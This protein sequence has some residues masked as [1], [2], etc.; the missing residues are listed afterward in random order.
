MKLTSSALVRATLAS[1]GSAQLTW[2]S[3][4]DELEDL[5][6][7][8]YGYRSTGLMALVTPCSFS[9]FGPG[10]NT[11]AEWVRAGFHDM[12]T[13]NIYAPAPLTTGGL[14]GSLMFELNDGENIGAGFTTTFATYGEFYSSR[15]SIADMIAL[16]VYAG[17]RTCGGPPVPIRPGRIDATV[18]GPLGVPQPQN[19]IG[20][21]ENQFLR[22]GFNYS[23]MIAMTACGHSLGGVHAGDF[24]NI[25]APGTVP[26]DYQL[27]DGTF[28]FDAN[29]AID[30]ISDNSTDPLVVGISIASGRNSDGHVF[31][32]ANDQNVTI[33][34]LA[35]PVTFRSTCASILQRMIERVPLTVT[36]GDPLQPYE[37]KPTAL[38]LTLLSGG[39]SITFSGEI[40]VRTTARSAD[41]I[42]SVQLVYL[43]RTGKNTCGDCTI[44]TSIAGTGS[45]FDETFTVRTALFWPRLYMSIAM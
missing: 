40:R 19:S 30:Y 4:F 14:D 44:N 21:F 2:P 25:V 35:N 37:V 33:T 18:A 3:Q 31:G 8:A 27:F 22:N 1:L 24:T 6:F 17:V 32:D 42:T 38:Q 29:V 26:N 16:G 5:M 34:S 28:E 12:S 13:G 45:G 36:L 41:E 39:A 11:A 43:D 23:D 20:T 10:R 15:T 9:I 7:Q